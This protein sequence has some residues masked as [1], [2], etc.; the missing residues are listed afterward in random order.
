MPLLDGEEL[1]WIAHEFAGAHLKD[2]RQVLSVQRIAAALAKTPH[3]SLTAA[4]GPAVRQAAHRIFEHPGTTIQGLLAGHYQRTVERCRAVPLV[5]VAED[6]C[7]FVYKQQQIKGLAQVNRSQKSRALIGHAA[8][9]LTPD[10]TPLGLLSLDLW[11]ELLD[12]PPRQAGAPLPVEERESEKWREALE[13]LVANVAPPASGDPKGE[14]AASTR[15]LVVADREADIARYLTLPRPP[16]VH[17]LVRAAQNRKVT[18]A[19]P[20]TG[21]AERQGLLQAVAQA[22][23]LGEHV[24]Q[25]PRHLATGKQQQIMLPAR[26]ARLELRVR[27]V[28]LAARGKGTVATTVWVVEAKE[29]EPPEDTPA[30]HWV[31]ITTE[32]VTDLEAARLRVDY[33]ARRWVVERLHYTLK[34]GLRAERL[35]IDDAVSLARALAIY[36]VVAWRLLHLTYLGRERPD[37]PASSAFEADELLV[38]A[39]KTRHPVTTVGEAVLA[40]AELGGW[41]RYRTA[42]PPGVK[43]MWMGWITLR[44]MV[45]G[46]RLART[47]HRTVL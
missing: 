35:Q 31:L 40:V 5:L 44:A 29:V 45:D 15:V 43:S 37:E 6:T 22:P 1:S 10:G 41:Q 39:A 8:L 7:Y 46:Y 17:H 19:D 20:D 9:A 32:A 33:Y 12:A 42:P 27:R 26:Q 30:I 25:V 24:V 13:R 4:C 3:R 21:A 47:P 14:E 11:G 2:R 36:Y 23:V 16:N 34:S 28:E 18:T 38:L